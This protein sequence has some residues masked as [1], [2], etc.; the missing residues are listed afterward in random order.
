LF[1]TSASESP[2]TY[3]AGTVAAAAAA[4]TEAAMKATIAREQEATVLAP[5]AIA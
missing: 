2:N 5:I 3:I 4:R 1:P